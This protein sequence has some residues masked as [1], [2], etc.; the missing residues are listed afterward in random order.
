[1]EDSKVDVRRKSAS[2]QAQ[3]D[4]P[5]GNNGILLC[6]HHMRQLGAAVQV[7]FPDLRQGVH[8]DDGRPRL[9]IQRGG[10]S[11]MRVSS[12]LRAAGMVY[13]RCTGAKTRW[14]RTRGM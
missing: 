2:L 5:A 1:M 6:V 12:K 11:R 7:L 14:P 13:Q 9:R 4:H 3:S 8:A 10:M